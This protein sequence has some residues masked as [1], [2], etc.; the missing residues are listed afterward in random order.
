LNHKGAIE[1][2]P[3]TPFI[4]RIFLPSLPLVLVYSAIA[5]TETDLAK[6]S[7]NP[8]ANIISLPFE[9]NAYFDVGPSGK[10]MYTMNIK[11]VYPTP[12][13][14]NLNLINRVVAPVIYLE[15]QDE[16]DL[17]PDQVIDAGGS[18]VFPGTSNEFGLGNIQYMAYFS[19][20]KPGKVI[21]GL[22]PVLELP[23]NTDSALGTDTWSAGP[24]A[25]VLT[26]P[27]NWVVGVLAQNIW[28]FA[29]DSDE[30]DINKSTLQP[31]IN[32]NLNAGW[33]LSAT[34]TMTANWEADSGDEWTVP[35]GGGFGRLIRFG[36]QPVDF[37][38][39]SYWNVEK[40]QFG[41]DWSMQFTVKFLIPKS[42]G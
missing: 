33:Y 11:P 14:E 29:G 20:A 31:I 26:M 32:Y 24:A 13:G 25:V 6:Q 17:T 10:R 41:A 9:N 27:G 42:A 7:Q 39:M 40:P 2:S 18:F 34:T 16:K 36:K 38:L 3:V 4:K 5:D 35:L 30:P 21:W 37:K 28:D 19:P 15:G 22:G 23:T 8:V 12:V 1:K